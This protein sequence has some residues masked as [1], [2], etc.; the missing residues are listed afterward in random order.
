MKHP[1]AFIPFPHRKPA[2]LV[3]LS[4]TFF[5][6]IIFQ[7]INTPLINP[8]APLGIISHQLAW[9]SDNAQ[10]ILDSWDEHARLL[11]AFSLGIDYLF[12]LFYAL[13]IALATLV[14]AERQ[15][16][17]FS[18][19]GSWAAYGIFIAAILDAVENF[20]QWQQLFNGQI[21]SWIMILVGICATIKFT[22]LITTLSCTLL[23]KVLQAR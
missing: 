17:K 16:G 1:L 11:A 10:L 19:L 6:L 9:T 7:L 14:V 4:G 2:F 15:P 8:S 18:Y 3:L 13:T 23:G 5:L 22:L 21:A 12:M 20:G